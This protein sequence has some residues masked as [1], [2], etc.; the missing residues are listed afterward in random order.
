V[1]GS[2]AVGALLQAQ[3]SD[4]LKTSAI[5]H[6]AGLPPQQRTLF[7]ARFTGSTG[8]LDI[9]SSAGGIT[10]PPGTPPE[11]AQLAK[12]IFH[13]GYVNAM[14]V[15]LWLPI[16]VLALGALSVLLV[17]DQTRG[18]EDT[19]TEAPPVAVGG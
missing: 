2:A 12:T 16:V 9:G 11:V 5:A 10:F 1:I 4:K 6:T 17:R 14:R 13:E 19:D 8:K 15:T 3:L 18:R 7:L